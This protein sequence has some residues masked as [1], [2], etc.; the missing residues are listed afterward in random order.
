MNK[1][2]I[3]VVA[4]FLLL[5]LSGCKEMMNTPIKKTEEFLSKYQSLDKKVVTELENV[6][7]NTTFDSMNEENKKIYV[8]VMKRQYE[9][10]VYDIKEEKIDGKVAEVSVAI[11][12]FDYAKSLNESNNYISSHESEFMTNN[13]LDIDKINKYKLD[14]MLQAKEK[15]NYFLNL[16]LTNIE[17]NWSF[18]GITDIERKKIQGLYEF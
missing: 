6:T 5:S 14:K 3:I 7:N 10:L 15:I 16:H 4:V 8:K 17:G 13:S 11:T 18:D 12:V 9:N 1:N 2:I